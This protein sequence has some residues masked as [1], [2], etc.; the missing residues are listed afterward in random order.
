[1]QLS[2]GFIVQVSASLI[3]RSKTHFHNFNGVG[4]IM[5]NNG[6]SLLVIALTYG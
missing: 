5:S 1:M 6:I 4:V 3:K 2:T